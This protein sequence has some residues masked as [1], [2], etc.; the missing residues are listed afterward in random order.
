MRSRLSGRSRILVAL[1]VVAVALAACQGAASPTPS[2]TATGGAFDWKKFSG[3]EITALL[4]QHP[5]TDGMTPLLEEFTR[6]TGIKVNPQTFSEDLYFDKM[7]QTLR[8][9]TEGADVYFL[10]MDSTGFTQFSAADSIFSVISELNSL[11]TKPMEI[12]L[13][14]PSSVF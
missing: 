11:T 13:L 6:E 9:T 5:W 8:S 3:A 1:T 4:N 2:P 14:H 12:M 7:E 10:P